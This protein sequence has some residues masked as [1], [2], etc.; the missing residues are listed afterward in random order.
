MYTYNKSDEGEDIE[1]VTL[2]PIVPLQ[3]VNGCNGIA[4]GWK[5]ESPNYSLIDIVKYIKK[6]LKYED[7]GNFKLIPSYNGYTGQITID[8]FGNIVNIGDFKYDKRK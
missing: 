7:V 8:D 3:L 6:Y 1:P 2:Y 5:S 4:M